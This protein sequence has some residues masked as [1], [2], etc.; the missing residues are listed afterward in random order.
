MEGFSLHAVTGLIGTV[1]SPS[2]GLPADVEVTDDADPSKQFTG[3]ADNNGVFRFP[4]LPPGWYSIR[5]T[6]KGLRDPTIHRART[7]PGMLT[8]VGEIRLI[9]PCEEEFPRGGCVFL[10]GIDISNMGGKIEMTNDLCAVD[11]QEEAPWCI[12]E[13]GARGA[14]SPLDDLHYAFWFHVAGDGVWLVPLTGV[15]FS[16][17]PYPV[18]YKKRGCPN[19]SYTPGPVRIDSLPPGTRACVRTRRGGYAEL[20]FNQPITPKQKTA[21]VD[22]VYWASQ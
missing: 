5:V 9:A 11:L 17:N 4:D 16:L 21:T 20:R 6:A 10:H 14:I 15:R 12:V 22:F 2:G 1:G 18:T 8:D 19:A 13:L 7:Q 3:R